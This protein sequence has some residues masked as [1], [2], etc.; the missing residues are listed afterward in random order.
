VLHLSTIFKKQ[1]ESNNCANLDFIILYFAKKEQELQLLI[2]NDDWKEVNI[3]SIYQNMV[4]FILEDSFCKVK[5]KFF[6]TIF[7]ILE[8]TEKF[9]LTTKD[10]QFLL[11]SD[12]KY[13]LIGAMITVVKLLFDSQ[14]LLFLCD[15]SFTTIISQAVKLILLSFQGL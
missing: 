12:E 10:E 4:N 5:N 7:E 14:K 11:L 1:E 2:E 13:K 9:E 3:P 6:P 8:E 15:T